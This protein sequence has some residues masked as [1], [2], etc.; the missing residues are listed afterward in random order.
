MFNSKTTGSSVPATISQTNVR[1][2]V[3]NATSG[4]FSNFAIQMNN[5]QA[6]RGSIVGSR[7]IPIQ[8]FTRGSTRGRDAPEG[9]KNKR[10]S[11]FNFYT[12]SHGPKLKNAL[13]LSVNNTYD[14]TPLEGTT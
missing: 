10:V 3:M 11:S 8:K 9:E 7:H 4:N 1:Q 5:H 13:D 6:A 14:A 2:G 12:N